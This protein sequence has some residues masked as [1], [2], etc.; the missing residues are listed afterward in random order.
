M[1]AVNPV[2][3][4]KNNIDNLNYHYFISETWQSSCLVMITFFPDK[5]IHTI[6]RHTV[7]KSS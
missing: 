6:I 2:S 5:G 7:K 4:S 3:C 1:R